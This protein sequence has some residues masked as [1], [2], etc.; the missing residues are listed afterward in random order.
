MI[1][2]QGFILNFS[3]PTPA[4]ITLTGHD[5]FLI[6]YFHQQIKTYWSHNKEPLDRQRIDYQSALDLEKLNISTQ[7]YSLFT[8]FTIID[9]YYP[10]KIIDTA[11]KEAIINYL[12]QLNLSDINQLVIFIAPELPATA[13]KFLSKITGASALNIK[14]PY[15]SQVEQW[16]TMRLQ[17][18]N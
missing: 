3:T 1:K 2:Q 13:L 18:N 14:T 10:K 17:Q 15:K 11:S 16:I 4:F 8:T 7:N 6:N 12:H 9:V 5:P